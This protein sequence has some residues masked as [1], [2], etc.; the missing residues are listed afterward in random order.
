MRATVQRETGG[1][2]QFFLGFP[3]WKFSTRR[4]DIKL[5]HHLPLSRVIIPAMMG[6]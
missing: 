6:A 4:Y 1:R 2:Q 5:T 3:R